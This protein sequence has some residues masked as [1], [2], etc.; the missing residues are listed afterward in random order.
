MIRYVKCGAAVRAVKRHLSQDWLRQVT[1]GL[2]VAAVLALVTWSA[3]SIFGNT[4]NPETA[5]ISKHQAQNGGEQNAN[6]SGQIEQGDVAAASV[7]HGPFAN[8]QNGVVAGDVVTFAVRIFNGGPGPLTDVRVVAERFDQ[9]RPSA[10]LSAQ[11]TVTSA[12]ALVSPVVDSATVTT[13]DGKLL[14]GALQSN[15]TVQYR[16][17][18]AAMGPISAAVLKTGVDLPSVAPGRAGA[19]FV[20]F[21]EKLVPASNGAC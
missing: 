5:A 21:S 4:S 19:V 18:E 9:V 15:S 8:R 20:A 1:A 17:N 6:A 12:E 11:F 10:T 3:T 14:C 2:V 7:D 16:W 13:A